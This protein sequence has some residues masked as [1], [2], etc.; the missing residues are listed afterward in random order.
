MRLIFTFKI[1]KSM[2]FGDLSLNYH[3]LFCKL[4]FFTP[5]IV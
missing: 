4:I 5:A 1:V 3:K 2:V